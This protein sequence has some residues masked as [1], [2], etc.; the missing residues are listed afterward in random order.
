MRTAR[1]MMVVCGLMLAACAAG[2]QSPDQM[3][4][5]LLQQRNLE[6]QKENDRLRGDL[7]KAISERDAAI[8]RAK[9]LQQQLEQ[10]AQQPVE[11]GPKGWEF[12]GP[13][14]WTTVGTDFLFDSGRATLR[15]DGRAKLEQIVREVQASFPDRAIWVLG[16]TD[17]DP[18]KYTKD[19]WQ[20]NLDLSCNRAM[21]VYREMMKL[22]LR[23]ERMIAGGQGEWFPKA[24]NATR[25]GKQQNRRV[26]II[27][28]PARPAIGTPAAAPAE[29]PTTPTPGME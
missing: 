20:D 16:H 14:A 18:I 23:P 9:A 19:K 17:T 6:L 7:A 28:V 12:A 27:A 21:T 2:C 22:G 25:A 4:I 5:E 1:S 10:L 11:T 13:Y 26:E 24:T 8:A 29:A 15:A 3:Q